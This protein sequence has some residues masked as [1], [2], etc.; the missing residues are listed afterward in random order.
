MDGM[1]GMQL[2]EAV[3]GKKKEKVCKKCVAPLA[4]HFCGSS[5]GR[6]NSLRLQVGVR[7]TF[8]TLQIRTPKR[9]LHGTK[10]RHMYVKSR[11]RCTVRKDE[12]HLLIVCLTAACKEAKP[13]GSITKGRSSNSNTKERNGDRGSTSRNNKRTKVQE[14]AQPKAVGT[15]HFADC[16]YGSCCAESLSSRE[17]QFWYQM[18]CESPSPDLQRVAFSDTLNVLWYGSDA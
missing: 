6:Q 15:I 12:H 17:G 1:D 14:G 3:K 9:R 10:H 4:D 5:C 11:R 13:S 18:K 7:Y 8:L 16:L 2:W